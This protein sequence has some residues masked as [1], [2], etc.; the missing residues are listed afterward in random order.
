MWVLYEFVETTRTWI[1][2]PKIFK[3]YPAII[4]SVLLANFQ[5]KW[6]YCNGLKIFRIDFF[7]KFSHWNPFWNILKRSL[8]TV[9]KYIIVYNIK[10]VFENSLINS[11]CMNGIFLFYLP[12]VLFFRFTNFFPYLSDFSKHRSTPVDHVESSGDDFAGYLQRHFLRIDFG[13][14]LLK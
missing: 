9:K 10:Y 5:G 12:K 11:R 4:C 13:Q 1:W 7:E 8:K 6:S 3:A 2:T 14:I